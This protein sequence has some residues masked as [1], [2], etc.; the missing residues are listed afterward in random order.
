MT[1]PGAALGEQNPEH[2]CFRVGDVFCAS[3]SPL[4]R[5]L[6]VTHSCFDESGFFYF[7]TVQDVPFNFHVSVL[8]F[9]SYPRY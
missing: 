3:L 6:Q 4:A 7:C 5:H 1:H 8:E 9:F 2:P